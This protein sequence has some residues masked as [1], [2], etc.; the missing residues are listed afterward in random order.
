MRGLAHIFI[1]RLDDFIL[2]FPGR[3]FKRCC[4]VV[5][6]FLFLHSIRLLEVL[7]GLL[8][9]TVVQLHDA[10]CIVQCISDLLLQCVCLSGAVP[11]NGGEVLPQ[12]GHKLVQLIQ[13]LA[14]QAL[15]VLSHVLDKM[16][17]GQN[18]RHGLR[19]NLPA[20]CVIGKVCPVLL[21][22]NQVVHILPSP[23]QFLED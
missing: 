23:G 16:A 21:L 10:L 3:I 17:V 1:H 5:C 14:E 19:H 2:L 20:C 8:C 12:V 4:K 13:Q 15:V 9:N 6:R 7:H 22:F 18:V 11:A